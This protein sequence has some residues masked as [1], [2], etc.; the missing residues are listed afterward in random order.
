MKEKYNLEIIL[1]CKFKFDF[2]LGKFK[3]ILPIPKIFNSEWSFAQF[4]IPDSRSICAFGPDSSIIGII[5][6]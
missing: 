2:S 4:R 3:N 6:I 1:H 5:Y